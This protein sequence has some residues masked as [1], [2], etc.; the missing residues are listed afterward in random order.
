MRNIMA[1]EYFQV[2]LQITWSTMHNNLPI[3]IAP[4]Q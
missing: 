2:S 4:Q 3:L 1:H